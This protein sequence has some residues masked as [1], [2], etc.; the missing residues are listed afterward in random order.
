MPSG[1]QKSREYIK[2]YYD[3]VVVGGGINGAGLLRDLALHQVDC[4]LIDANDFCS[5]TSQS[6]SK[7]LHGGIRYLETLDFDLVSE[8]LNEKNLWL[9]LSPN[10]CYE[11][12]FY[13]PNYKNSKYPLIAMWG[14]IKLYDLLSKFKNS[15]SF[16][17]NKDQTLN[18]FPDLKSD[19]LNGSAVYFDA[20]VDDIRMGINCILDAINTG[21]AEAFNYMKLKSFKKINATY[22]LVIDDLISQKTFEI[23][24]RHLAFTTGPF[25]DK[26]MQQLN[27]DHWKPQLVPNKGIHLW[28]KRDAIAANSPI[29]IQNSDNRIIFVIPERDSVLVGTTEN[30]I[31]SVEFNIRPEEKEIEY[32]LKALNTYFPK[33][34]VTPNDILS[35]FAGIR[36]LVRE[37]NTNDISKT[38][39]RHLTLR[40]FENCFVIIGGKYTTFRVMVQDIARPI[41][42]NN[43]KSYNNNLTM[44]NFA[45]ESKILTFKENKLSQEIID[46]VIAEEQVHQ[47]EDLLVRRLYQNSE[48]HLSNNQKDLILSYKD[49]LKTI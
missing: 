22:E 1:Y 33:R 5:Q 14:A 34:P 2:K 32:L 21:F 20:I 9:K 18:L 39:R 17:I 15:S 46:K 3:T 4:L 48:N 16:T 7:M 30:L 35:S 24:C 38:S 37:P 25:T 11:S 6:S 19:N 27:V 8:A 44:N 13:L 23:K 36:P 47:F 40:P 10:D 31:N 26:L 29:V 28:L 12:K 43:G 49:K 42:L 45:K 41:V